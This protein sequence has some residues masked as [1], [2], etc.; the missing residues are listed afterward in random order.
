MTRNEAN[1]RVRFGALIAATAR[2][3][4]FAWPVLL[5]AWAARGL[6]ESIGP[7]L[8]AMGLWTARGITD[9]RQLAFSL[10]TTVTLALVS[11]IAIRWLL[12]GRTAA[13]RANSGLMGYVALIIGSQALQ[14]GLTSIITPDVHTMPSGEAALRFI[15]VAAASLLLSLAYAAL[16]LWPTSI[17]AGEPISPVQAARRMGQAYPVFV[18]AAFLLAL[19]DIALIQAQLWTHHVPRV[20]AD[21]LGSTALNSLEDTVLMVVLAQIYARRIRGADL[22]P[23]GSVTTGQAMA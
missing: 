19:P 10:G 23:A 17:L 2:T 5:A 4:L 12:D 9:P 13:A 11:G 21:Q 6:V 8:H 3:I 22:A 15:L 7:V 18:L 20:L 1:H 14:I 16:A